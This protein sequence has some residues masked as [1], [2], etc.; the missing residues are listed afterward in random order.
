MSF[1]QG[2]NLSLN[3]VLIIE[4]ESTVPEN[5]V[6]KIESAFINCHYQCAANIFINNHEVYVYNYSY[7]VNNSSQKTAASGPIT[8][9]PMWIPSGTI[10]NIG[11]NISGISVLEFNTE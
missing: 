11:S 10:I 7:D 9:F 3:Q 6:W 8:K 5:K 2:I 1:C 4:Q